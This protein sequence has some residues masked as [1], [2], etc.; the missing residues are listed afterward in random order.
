[1]IQDASLEAW[2]FMQDKLG[3][4]QKQVLAA[5]SMYP[6]SFHELR[7]WYVKD[8]RPIELAARSKSAILLVPENDAIATVNLLGM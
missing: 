1:M 7:A 2:R 5:I 3:Y 4:A 6:N 8:I